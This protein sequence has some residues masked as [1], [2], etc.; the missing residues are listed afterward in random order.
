MKR[1]T[2]AMMMVAVGLTLPAMAETADLRNM[3]P[4]ERHKAIQ[5]MSP[6]ERESF[7]KARQ[8]KWQGMS[9]DEKL[10]AIEK[11]RS[12]MIRE[13]ESHWNSLSPEEKIRKAEEKMK[14]GRGKHK[15]SE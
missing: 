5:N 6:E 14:E 10:E 13:R 3:S 9:Q 2:L 12:E 15:R 7:K 4:Q 8:E 11:R 1:M